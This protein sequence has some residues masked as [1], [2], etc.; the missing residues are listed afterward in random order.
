MGNFV[1]LVHTHLLE[2]VIPLYFQTREAADKAAKILEPS[3]FWV[4]KLYE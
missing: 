3:A 2:T 4:L 1:L